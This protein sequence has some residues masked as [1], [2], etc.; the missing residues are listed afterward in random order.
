MEITPEQLE[1]YRKSARERE[2]DQ[3]ARLEAR[4]QHAWELARKAA[5]ILKEEFGASRVVLFGSLLH[6]ELYHFRSDIDLAVWDIQHYFRAVA[7]LLD[8][9][10]EFDFDLVPFEDA[11]PGIIALIQR[12]GMDL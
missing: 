5:P 8:L 12:E 2:K 1:I 7:R 4:M 11:R 10:P 9:D 3:H 6:P